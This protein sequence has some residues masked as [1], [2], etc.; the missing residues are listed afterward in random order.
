M[1]EGPILTR[2]VAVYDP[3]AWAMASIS[4]YTPGAPQAM[5]KPP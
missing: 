4:P 2:L 5:D 1:G 3:W